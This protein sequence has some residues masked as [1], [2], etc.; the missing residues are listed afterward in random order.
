MLHE[1]DYLK[2]YCADI[3]ISI[4]DFGQTKRHKLLE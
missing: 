1:H 3:A 4:R 2:K